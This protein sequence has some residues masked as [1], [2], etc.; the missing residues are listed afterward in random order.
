MTVQDLPAVHECAVEGCSYN[1]DTACHAGAITVTGAAAGCGTFTDIGL[2]GGLPT[3]TAMVGAC[4]RSDCT[5]NS[6]LECHADSITV[7]PGADPA[8]CLTYQVA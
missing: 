7:G 2:T 1:H 5:H 8:D 3:K 4:H 6:A